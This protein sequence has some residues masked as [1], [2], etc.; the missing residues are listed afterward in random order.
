MLHKNLQYHINFHFSACAEFS[1]YNLSTGGGSWQ[2]AGDSVMEANE[3]DEQ[4]RSKYPLCLFIQT[5]L[6][7][8][9]TLKDWLLKNMDN[10]PKGVVFDYFEQVYNSTV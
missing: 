10:R 8:K 6:C 9:G 3:G 1:R 4:P 2:S 5:Q 7:R